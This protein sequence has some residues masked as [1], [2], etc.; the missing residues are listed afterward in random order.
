MSKSENKTSVVKKIVD[1]ILVIFLVF[2]LFTTILA[3]SST[4]GSEGIPS[5][6]GYG[7]FTIESDSM[8]PTFD[9]GDLI[10]VNL[11]A[12]K[13]KIK[14]GDIVTFVDKDLSEDS[15]RPVYNTH[16]V[17]S[18]KSQDG[19]LYECITK[20]DNKKT[21]LTADKT[22]RTDSDIKGVYTG[23]KIKGFGKVIHFLCTQKGFFF[24]ILL[25]LFLFFIYEI[26]NVVRL[27]MV[28]KNKNKKVISAEDE[29]AIKQQAVAEYLKMHGADDVK[30]AAE[31]PTAE[32]AP[33]DAEN[34]T[35]TEQKDDIKE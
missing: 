24:C 30:P 23:T 6:G 4:S 26:V 25:P 13:G 34:E 10:L 35:D 29:E 20:G 16:R 5:I 15:S 19:Y 9:T 7:F 11:K 14:K 31:E 17:V 28:V 8:S 2:A 12:D 27:A 33:N 32:E 3:I 18:V 1:I 21:C 22:P